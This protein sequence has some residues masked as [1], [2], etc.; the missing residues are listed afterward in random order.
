MSSPGCREGLEAIDRDG[1]RECQRA[2]ILSPYLDKETVRPAPVGGWEVRTD[3]GRRGRPGTQGVGSRNL[4]RKAQTKLAEAAMHD[5]VQKIFTG[6]FEASL[7]MLN[8][9]VQNCAPRH[10]DGRIAKYPF[11]QVAYHTLCFV[12][13]YL[14]P[15][16]QSFQLRD[17]HPHGWSELNDEYP[18]RRFDQREI[19]EYLAIC[20]QKAVATLASETRRIPAARGGVSLVAHLPR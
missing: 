20:R 10:W 13:L 2:V 8:D 6:Q 19:T 18:S 7:C 3:L 1:P 16:E 4:L 11:W 17:I 14:S 9:C 12:D 5:Y 15:D